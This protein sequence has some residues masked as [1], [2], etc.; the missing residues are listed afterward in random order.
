MKARLLVTA[1]VLGLCSGCGS[2]GSMVMYGP[3][4]PYQ[5]AHLDLHAITDLD[6]IKSTRG[7]I[8]PF[9]IIDLP[10]SIV[11]DTFLLIG[12]ADDVDLAHCPRDYH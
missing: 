6:S 7:L 4:C 12:N 3:F 8:I 5:G 2:I 9:G 1:F 11:S 10:F